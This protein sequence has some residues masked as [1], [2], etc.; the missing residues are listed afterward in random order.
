MRGSVALGAK[1]ENFENA[2]HIE[3]CFN[4]VGEAI[5]PGF[6]YGGMV[7]DDWGSVIPAHR[8]RASA[9]GPNSN[10]PCR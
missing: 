10:T 1:F 8:N 5:D 6:A 7:P 4:S 2:V 3:V 9:A